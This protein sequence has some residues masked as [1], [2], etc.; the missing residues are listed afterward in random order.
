MSHVFPKD[1][2]LR[3]ALNDELHIHPY[4]PLTPPE[5]VLYL[6]VLVTPEERH[7][8]DDH[9]ALL[10]QQMG[11]VEPI[12]R[13]NQVRYYFGD[14]RLK[15]ERHQEFTRYKFVYHVPDVAG[16]GGRDGG[17]ARGCG[18]DRRGAG[19]GATARGPLPA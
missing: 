4:E 3:H 8:E 5:R 9:L 12:H 11:H 19:R 2:A 1:Y 15:V 10:A 7:L 13:G 16:E 17:R 18:G 6:A 14:L